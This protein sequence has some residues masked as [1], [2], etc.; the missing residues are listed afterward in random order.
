MIQKP[1]SAILEK[2]RRSIGASPQA[3]LRE[4]AEVTLPP[5]CPE[6]QISGQPEGECHL[7]G[8]RI[9]YGLR[10][11]FSAPCPQSGQRMAGLY[12]WALDL[13]DFTPVGQLCVTTRAGVGHQISHSERRGDI[14]NLIEVP[15]THRAGAVT[16]GFNGHI[17]DA[18]NQIMLSLEL[19]GVRHEIGTGYP[20]PPKLLSG[21]DGWL[22]LAGDSNDSPGQF[23]G[24]HHP[25]QSWTEGWHRYFEAFEALR[26]SGAAGRPIYL[27][28][29]SKETLFPDAYPLARG[30]QT[31]FEAL[32]RNFGDRPGVYCPSELLRPL[33]ELA[34]DRAESHWTDFGARLVCEKLFELWQTGKP[35]LPFDMTMAWVSGDL[36]WK[37]VPPVQTYRPRASWPN[38][39]Q[40][41]FDNAIRHHGQIRVTQNLKPLK[42]QTCVIFGDS[43]GEYMERYLTAV[44]ARVVYV[45]STGAWDP[46]ILAHEHPTFTV[47]QCAERF[48]TRAPAPEVSTRQVVTKKLK[49]GEVIRPEP[50]ADLM[51]QWTGPRI[52]F[53]KEMG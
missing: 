13:D 36:G 19:D 5:A 30:A 32:W 47:L 9:G 16:C 34:Y 33:R 8:R 52:A 39:S 25:T 14:L 31:P 15:A 53:Y 17:P 50:R 22:F 26:S 44:F 18:G 3:R 51:A 4:S 37:A 43:F 10:V 2:F 24:A 21:R 38:A 46:E 42:P 12:G 35:S 41:I 40:V 1:F 45:Y 23:T 49:R 20:A 48:L 27:V 7:A 29:P 11:G 6:G 28:A